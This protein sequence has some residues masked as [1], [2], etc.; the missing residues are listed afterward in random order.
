MNEME[1]NYQTGMPTEPSQEWDVL[2]YMKERNIPLPFEEPKEEVVSLQTEPTQEPAREKEFP[3]QYTASQDISEVDS[4]DPYEYAK[5]RNIALPDTEMGAIEQTARMFG[6]GATYNFLDELIAGAKTGGRFAFGDL[7]MQDIPESY[8]LEQ[9]KQQSL[10][11]QIKQESP[12]LSAVPEFIGAVVSPVNK[13]LLPAKAATALKAAAPVAEQTAIQAAKQLPTYGQAL[14]EGAT[15]G[16]K[17]GGIAGIG[18]SEAGI[19][20]PSKLI[21]EGL[22]YAIPG[23]VFGG[24]L[25]LAGRG[26]SGLGQRLTRASVESEPG[27]IKKNLST[28]LVTGLEGKDILSIKAEDRML[29]QIRQ[30]AQSFSNSM[31]EVSDETS[32]LFNGAMELLDDTFRFIKSNQFKKQNP[33][34]STKLDSILNFADEI[35]FERFGNNF[36]KIIDDLEEIGIINKKPFKS[37]TPETDKLTGLSGASRKEMEFLEEKAKYFAD[38]P[39]ATELIKNRINERVVGREADVRTSAFSSDEQKF[40]SQLSAYYKGMMSPSQEYSFARYMAGD[41]VQGLGQIK[42]KKLLDVIKDYD[43]T[44]SIKEIALQKGDELLN[45][46]PTADPQKQSVG[47]FL[48]KIRDK[49]KE[50]RQMMEYFLSDGKSETGFSK[51]LA[52]NYSKQ[53]L[54]IKLAEKY[55]QMMKEVGDTSTLGSEGRLGLRLFKDKIGAVKNKLNDQ[56]SDYNNLFKILDDS[57]NLAAEWEIYKGVHARH[58][59]SH[60]AAPDFLKRVGSIGGYAFAHGVGRVAAMPKNINNWLVNAT[61]DQLMPL[62][63]RLKQTKGME[64]IGN[65]LESSLQNRSSKNA[66]L[67]MIMQNPNARSLVNDLVGVK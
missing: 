55:E 17:A 51:E 53:E 13:L 4:F 54:K 11:K 62:I 30:N 26:L 22:E 7:K 46:I 33:Q 38:E 43:L 58:G 57:E 39:N 45:N 44:Q 52:K 47:N 24:G 28:A 15:L 35:K 20:E 2:K 48:Q 42:N 67:F 16:F 23:T 19:T 63:Q 36:L 25:G 29:N 34:L 41:N 21:Q 49:F 59:G 50:S 12:H 3:T 61:D 5:K 6:K 56:D 9:Q 64:H 32:E 31:I 40:L 65:S 37:V 18:E 66:A 60:S 14:K 8:R 10:E 1:Y 27:T